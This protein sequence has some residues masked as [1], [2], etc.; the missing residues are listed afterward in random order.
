[1][2]NSDFFFFCKTGDTLEMLEPGHL[3]SVIN[4]ASVGGWWKL[5]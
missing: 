5:F 2:G 4:T 3:Y 1:M